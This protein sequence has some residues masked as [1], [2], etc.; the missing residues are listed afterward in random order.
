MEKS[1]RIKKNSHFRYIYGHGKSYSDVNLVLYIL[2]NRK[3]ENRVGISVSKKVG[4][5]VKRN[6]VKRL[7][8]ENYRLNKQLFKPG[9]DFIFIAREAASRATF[10]DIKK[11]MLYL[12]KVK[13]M[14]REEEIK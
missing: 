5:S 1:D 14:I 3:K 10:N 6:R 7:I 11:S 2:R 12:M 8:R 13:G 9:Y 4:N